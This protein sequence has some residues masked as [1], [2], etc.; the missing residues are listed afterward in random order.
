[1]LI[2]CDPP[3][4]TNT[5]FQSDFYV[6]DIKNNT[7]HEISRDYS[8]QGG[9]EAGFTQRSTFDTEQQEFYVLSGLMRDNKRNSTSKSS[10][11]VYSLETGQW[12]KIYQNEQTDNKHWIQQTPSE[13]CPRFAHQLVYDHVNKVQYLFGG[14]PGEQGN[15]KQRLDDFWDLRLIRPTTE[16]ILRQVRFHI[17]KQK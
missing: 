11:W 7:V 9:P 4:P 14:N 2:N 3:L 1:M 5:S 8:K 10:F 15:S 13:P 17:R 12:I 16:E 6:Y